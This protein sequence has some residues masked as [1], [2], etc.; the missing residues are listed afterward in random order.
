MSFNVTAE[1]Y[2]HCSTQFAQHLPEWGH[3]AMKDQNCSHKITQQQIDIQA[4]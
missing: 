4:L 1:N 3:G 2:F